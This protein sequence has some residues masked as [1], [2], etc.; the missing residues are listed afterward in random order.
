[1]SATV[2]GGGFRIHEPNLK[3]CK[4]TERGFERPQYNAAIQRIF[5]PLE[6]LQANIYWGTPLTEGLKGSKRRYP[7]GS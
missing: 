2:S 1:M 3:L 7:S 6:I 5:L 4:T